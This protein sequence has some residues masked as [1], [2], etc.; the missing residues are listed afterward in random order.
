MAPPVFKLDYAASEELLQKL[1]SE[2][3]YALGAREIRKLLDQR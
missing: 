3:Q 1:Y 2:K